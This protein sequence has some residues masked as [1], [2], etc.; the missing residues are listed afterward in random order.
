LLHR[1]P[2]R[3]APTKQCHAGKN[4]AHQLETWGY[5]A[6]PPALGSSP[7]SASVP[8]PR[9]QHLAASCGCQHMP[10][11][12]LGLSREAGTTPGSHVLAGSTAG[13]PAA[14]LPW[15]GAPGTPST[16][17]RNSGT[18]PGP[19]LALRHAVTAARGGASHNPTRQLRDG[20]HQR[21]ASPTA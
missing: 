19:V 21:E 20:R 13:P 11:L 3:S 1:P 7:C 12:S 16:P 8:P 6:P 5:Q 2:A 18:P 4:G 14:G 10:A 9:P 17:A 15:A